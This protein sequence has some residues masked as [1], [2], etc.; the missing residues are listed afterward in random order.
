MKTS[1]DG[2]QIGRETALVRGLPSPAAF[3][4]TTL[5]RDDYDVVVVGAGFAGLTAARELGTRGLRV[6][7][8]EARDRIGGRTFVTEQGGQKYEIGGTWVHWGQPF[9][10]SELH[11]YGLAVSESLSGTADTMSVL[12]AS[13]LVTDTAQAVG[14]ELDAAL[15]AYCDI[16]GAQGRIAFANPH[17]REVDIPS[18]LD[19][20][21]LADRLASLPVSGRQRDLLQSFLT[22][23]A[24]TDP[25]RGGLYDQL[26]WWALGDYNVDS[27]LKRLGRYKIAQGTSAL[28][29]ALLDDS[30]ADLAVAQPVS[31][32]EV[33]DGVVQVQA[34]SLSVRCKAVVVAVPMN[35]LGDIDFAPRLAP[36]RAAAHQERHVCAGTKFIARVDRSVGAW[37]GFAPYPNPLTMVVADR[38]VDGRSILVGFGPDDAVDIGNLRRVESELR[39]FLPGIT[40]EEVFAH[41]WTNDPYAKGAWTWFAPG[42]ARRALG[43]LQTPAPPLFFAN[44]DWATGWRGFID[45]AIEDGLR[46]ARDAMSHLRP[47]GR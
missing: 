11:R 16:D 32:I 36:A 31:R 27:L 41:D 15:T 34:R 10:W 35:V 9:V 33:A 40:V 28:A 29:R 26:K 39:K 1:S 46:G 7:I 5:P 42:Q 8:V 38:E 12:T 18:A 44:T 45:G 17:A 25:A 23:N 6:A 47:A 37:V 4:R 22:M 24:A 14:Q 21:S 2:L 13:G 43:A 30:G 20:L 19:Q 3:D